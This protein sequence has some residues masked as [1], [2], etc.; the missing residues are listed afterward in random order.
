[1]CVCVPVCRVKGLM[2]N[3]GDREALGGMAMVQVGNVAL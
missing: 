3:L 1:M 2:L